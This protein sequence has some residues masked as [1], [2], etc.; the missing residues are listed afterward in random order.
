LERKGRG[1]LGKGAGKLPGRQRRCCCCCAPNHPAAAVDATPLSRAKTS[2][3]RV[4][5]V[6]ARIESGLRGR[7]LRG[8]ES[9]TARRSP[10]GSSRTLTGTGRRGTSGS[11]MKA[12]RRRERGGAGRR[13]QDDGGEGPPRRLRTEGDRGGSPLLAAQFSLSLS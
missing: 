13:K 8:G 12:A 11:R 7:R 4:L 6:G 10:P 2:G 9:G 5:C 1:K 3:M